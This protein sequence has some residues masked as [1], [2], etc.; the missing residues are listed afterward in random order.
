MTPRFFCRAWNV[1]AF[2]CLLVGLACTPGVGPL[3]GGTSETTNGVSATVHNPNG[4]PA[5]GAAVRLRRSDYV[6]PVSMSERNKS[7]VVSSD[8]LTDN[9]GR[10]EIRRIDPGSYLIEVT[11]GSTGV[12]LACS[13]STDDSL[14]DFGSD[15][16]RSFGVIRTTVDTAG[17][18]GNRLYAQIAGLER[19]VAVDSTGSFTMNDIPAGT[20]SVRVI[21]S[22]NTA[23]VIR[24][25]SVS[26]VSDDTTSIPMTGWRFSKRVYINTAASGAN[27]VENVYG[28]PLLV[29]LD[30]SNFD[31]S[32]AQ[33]SGQ[34]I[35]FTKS[36]NTP[37]SYEIEQWDKAGQKAAIWV[38]MDTVYGNNDQQYVSLY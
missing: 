22:V 16:L 13:F 30:Q 19:L 25:D 12:V 17:Q 5:A 9:N 38:K 1:P 21:S 15:T 31:F 26:V 33:D 6:T 29:R 35:R 10:F 32:A 23:P 4:T 28:F 3:S 37:L 8:A 18:S 24:R 27:V 34:D 14:Q 2:L 11:T 7:A 20:F 36:D